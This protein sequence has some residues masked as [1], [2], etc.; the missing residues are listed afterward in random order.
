MV[1]NLNR[2]LYTHC[3]DSLLLKVGW[4]SPNTGSLDPG[5]YEKSLTLKLL[6]CQLPFW[7]W[8]WYVFFRDRWCARDC[9]EERQISQG[10]KPRF[11]PRVLY[12]AQVLQGVFCCRKQRQHHPCDIQY[13]NYD[14]FVV[15]KIA[16][17]VMC[18][19]L[20]IDYPIWLLF[21]LMSWN[22]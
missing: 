14:R 3:K 11:F 5:A 9:Y 19:S 6:T 10:P 8:T 7:C 21:L 2:S 17:W 12:L 13:I 4:P 20:K 18:Y 16:I 15:S 22:H 1:I